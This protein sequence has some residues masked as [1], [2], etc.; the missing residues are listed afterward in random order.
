MSLVDR[1]I[2]RR[3]G[4]IPSFTVTKV[5][6]V[7]VTSYVTSCLRCGKLYEVEQAA[8]NDGEDQSATE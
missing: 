2:C 4:H 3:E 1:F 5:S 8:T 6:G 7:T